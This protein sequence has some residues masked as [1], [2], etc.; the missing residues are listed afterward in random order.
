MNLPIALR[1]D[2]DGCLRPI[3]YYDEKKKREKY[4]I[5]KD[6]RYPFFELD[7]DNHFEDVLDWYTKHHLDVYVHRTMRGFHFL[8]LNALHK[9]AYAAW[10]RPIMKYNPKCPMVTL[11]IKPNKWVNEKAVF[12]KGGIVTW[13]NKANEQL[14]MLKRMIELQQMGML[15]M[16][17]YIVKYRITGELGNL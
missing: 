13:D 17:Y 11:R 10:I 1:E 7:D 2:A 16:K 4:E 6:M 12:R 14:E 8:S 3:K 15:A 9:D 5:V